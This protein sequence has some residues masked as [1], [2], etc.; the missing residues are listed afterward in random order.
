MS[1]VDNITFRPMAVD[2]LEAVLDIERVSFPAPWCK[3]HFVA[4]LES[5]FS[6]PMVVTDFEGN[7]LGYIC[8]MLVMD[9]GHILNVAVRPDLRGKGIGGLLV[10]KVI[11]ECGFL[12]AEYVSLEVRTSNSVA[13]SLYRQIGFV[14]T[15]R[16]NKYYENGEDAFIMEYIF[17]SKEE[18]DNAV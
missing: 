10:R 5:S 15:G 16:R 4:E 8:P 18:D 12:G 13:I 7:I 9:E 3:D 11:D 2:D 14:I 1:E 6:F 17:G